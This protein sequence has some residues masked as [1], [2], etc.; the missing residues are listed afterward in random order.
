MDGVTSV[1][2]PSVSSPSISSP[3]VREG[4][5]PLGHLRTRQT[6]HRSLA[7]SNAD[8][9]IAE[10]NDAY[11]Q[12]AAGKLRQHAEITRDQR[13]FAAFRPAL[14]VVFLRDARGLRDVTRR[15]LRPSRWTTPDFSKYS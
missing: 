7:L 15:P 12:D 3:T 2:S 13:F 5:P 9:Q 14:L 11:R 8:S 1:S 4:R 6:R 10:N